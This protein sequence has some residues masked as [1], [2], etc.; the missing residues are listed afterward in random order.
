MGTD[1]LV[2]IMD[3][4]IAMEIVQQLSSFK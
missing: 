2:K 4:L 1:T 3:I